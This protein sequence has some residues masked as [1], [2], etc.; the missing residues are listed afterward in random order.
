[1]QVQRAEPDTFPVYALLDNI[2]SAW[3]VGAMFRTADAVGLRGLYL[4]GMTATPPRA[5]LEKTSLGATLSVPWDYWDDA[6]AAARSIKERGLPLV[7]LEQTD[8]AEAWDRADYAFPHCFVVGHEVTGVQSEILDLADQVVDIPMMGMK[9]S[10]NVAV[11][12]GIL[13]Y[14]IRRRW[15]TGRV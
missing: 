11:S 9:Q 4:C 14:E 5:D 8:R 10:L 2:R 1:M 13:A 15:Q 6:V 12:F 7:V 3:N